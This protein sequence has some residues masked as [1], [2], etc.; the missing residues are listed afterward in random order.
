MCATKWAY[1]DRLGTYAN[2][3]IEEK[4][5]GTNLDTIVS[6]MNRKYPQSKFSNGKSYKDIASEYLDGCVMEMLQNITTNN[7]IPEVSITS[8]RSNFTYRYNRKHYWWIIY[9]TIILCG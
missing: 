3:D 4:L 7:T 2:M 9:T 5:V 6:G 1:I 8:I